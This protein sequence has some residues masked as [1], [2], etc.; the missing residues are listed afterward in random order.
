MFAIFG[1]YD[2]WR[3]TADAEVLRFLRG[4]LTTLKAFILKYRNPGGP[5]DYCLKHGKAQPKYHGVVTWQLRSVALISGDAYFRRVAN[6]FARDYVYR[7]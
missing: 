3:V 4:T 7:P 2:Y 5:A 6:L 1:L